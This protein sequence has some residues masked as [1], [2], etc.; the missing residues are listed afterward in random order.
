MKIHLIGNSSLRKSIPKF[1]VNFTAV[2]DFYESNQFGEAAKKISFSHTFR[3]GLFLK[4]LERFFVLEQF[5]RLSKMEDIFHAELD[6]LLFRTDQLVNNLDKTRRRGIF[7]PFHDENSAVASVLYCN[8]HGSLKSLIDFSNSGDEFP[9]EM[10]LIAN[11]AAKNSDNALALPTLASLISSSKKISSRA[12][13]VLQVNQLGGVIDAAQL[14][15]W[16]GGIDP[17]N[18]PIGIVPKT[19]FVDEP[20][21]MLLTREQLI[22]TRF[23]INQDS[24]NLVCNY[25]GESEVNVYNLHLHSKIHRLLLNSNSGLE[26]LLRNANDKFPTALPGTRKIQVL[27]YLKTRSLYMI[28]NPKKVAAGL[29]RR[30]H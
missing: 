20:K 12:I 26:E 18:V 27:E 5:M 24:G 11:W 4:S 16:V 2:E 14:G 30:M 1:E 29:F 3:D 7:I 19:K 10:A 23:R 17:R 15:Q 25:N 28:R 21:A 9:H 13:D 8:D 22:M 6:Q